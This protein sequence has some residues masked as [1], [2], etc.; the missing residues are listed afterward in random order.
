MLADQVESS[1]VGCSHSSTGFLSSFIVVGATD[2][3]KYSTTLPAK[4]KWPQLSLTPGS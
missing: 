4:T 3:V 1:V 2:C